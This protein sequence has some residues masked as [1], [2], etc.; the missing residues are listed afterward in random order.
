MSNVVRS[1][2]YR[3]KGLGLLLTAFVLVLTASFGLA[4]CA[5]VVSGNGT[6][7]SGG[8]GGGGTPDTTPP[9]VSISSP[10]AGA[11]LSGTTSVD[12]TASDNVGVTSV[13]LKIDSASFGAPLTAAPYVVAVNTN[14]LSNGN[15]ILTAT[16]SDAAGNVGTSASVTVKVNNTTSNPTPTVA[17]LSP[18]NG[19]S[20]S[21]T[22]M[23]SASATDSVGISHVQF[24]LDGANAGS[25]VTA[26]PYTYAW[27]S[28]KSANGAHILRAVATDMSGNSASSSNVSVTVNNSTPDTTPPAVSITSPVN[29]ATVANTITLSANATDNV[30]VAHVQFRVDGVNSGALD[31]AAPYTD[32]LNTKTLANGAHTITAVATDTSN[33]SAT[34]AAITIHVNNTTTDTTP[35]TVAITAPL[36]G[37]TVS[38]TIALSANATDNVAVA[39]VQF[40]VDG[41]NSGAPDTSAPYAISLN[42]T[43]LSNGNHTLTAVATDTS[44]NSS[45]SAAITVHVNN[46]SADTTPPS[47]PAGLRASAVS[48]SQISLTWTAS[49]DNV[50]VTGYRIYRGGSQVGTSTGVTFQD[51]GL[52]ASTTYS[53][54]VAAFDAAGNVS[55]QSASASATTQSGSSSSGVPSA[56]G[57]FQIPNSAYQSVCPNPTQFNGINGSEGCAGVINDWNGGFADTTRNRLVWWGG[58][59]AGYYGNEVYY[60]DLQTLQIGRY[61]DPVQGGAGS[62]Q[63][64]ASNPLNDLN[65]NGTPAAFHDYQGQVY[66]PTID[67]MFF[68]MG[69]MSRGT[70]T[71]TGTALNDNLGR[72]WP[73]WLFKFG[74]LPNTL[75]ASNTTAWHPQD[76]E[77]GGTLTFSGGKGWA[78]DATPLGEYASTTYDPVSQQVYVYDQYAMYTWDPKTNVGTLRAKSGVLNTSSTSAVVSAIDPVHR[79]LMIYGNNA[80]V[81]YDMTANSATDVSGQLSGCGPTLGTIAPGIDFDTAENV[82]VTWSG[83][84]T[85]YLLNA[86]TSAVSTQ[87][88]SVPAMSCLPVT[89]ANGPGAQ[90]VNGTYGRFRY[91]P[92]IGVFAVVNASDRNAYALRLTPGSGGTGGGTSA[93]VISAVAANSIATSSAAVVWTTNIAATSQVEYGT[94]TSYGA[95]TAVN[96]A[97]VTAHNVGLS[98]LAASTL[99]HYRVHSKDSGGVESISGDAAFATNGS[100]DTT[101]PTVSITAPVSG[102]TVS[103]ATQ[104]SANAADNVGV[105]GVQFML[106]SVNLGAEL[107]SAPY[108][109]SWDTTV[110]TNGS[111]T[112]TARA[113]DAAGNSA[114]STAVTVNVNNAASSGSN[115]FAQRCAAAG[116]IKCVGFDTT[117][118]ILPFISADGNG[119]MQASLDTTVSASGGGSLKFVIPA[120]SGQN[121][122]GSW[123]DSLGAAFPPGTTFFVQY[124]QRFSPE[125]I[126]TNYN[127]NGWKQSIFHM[128]G[129]T[130]ASI[131]LTTQNTWQHG[132][133]E[134]YT[135]CGARGFWTNLPGGDQLLEQG[136]T[137]S[138]GY[139]CHYSNQVP[140]SCAF[141]QPN[142]WMT[143]YYEVHVGNWGQANSTIKAW[144]AYEGGPMK[145]F[146][147]MQGY[148][149]NY[150]NSPSDV[151]DHVTLLPYNT[152]KV[153]SQTNPV[154]Y[155]WYDELIVSRNPI[156]APTGPTPAP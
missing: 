94:S 63:C 11:S 125:F 35:P 102:T 154:A 24:Q 1:T 132:F 145:E 124:R 134:M 92:S 47:V 93:P 54:T 3:S 8:S 76:P 98:G 135:D 99:Y 121:S 89:Y 6:K 29:G 107:T 34:S 108:T 78:R 90:G 36:N 96:S 55:A 20:V 141:Y 19:A 86:T 120:N 128:G 131:E 83:G 72:A 156:P 23:L 75:P 38:G 106:D 137:S 56:L 43:L 62:N 115:S 61:T 7:T 21:K 18:A 111:H 15:H 84:N 119:V 113:R 71:C 100:G 25:P 148:T 150:N 80:A 68:T 129:S 116:V 140:A 70:N 65:W 110:I 149:L 30:A 130:C 133:P 122:S 53:Y 138:T 155:T 101:P 60:L 17:L 153:Q 40:R 117:A 73:T 14:S 31:T 50:G 91:F 37:A 2:K 26:A 151:Y 22:V 147:N 139:N 46:G 143:F 49:T 95:T 64:G 67:A 144:V 66:V 123:S 104:V 52:N 105:V 10:A 103:G 13:Q 5:G 74:E 4:G 87:Y 126:N 28:T 118:E 152:H 12:I 88:G 16:A 112:L 59:H 69:D 42:T 109:T 48:S 82:F 77:F 136:D 32:S 85:V 51:G 57:W 9:T 41:V 97:M 81:K 146:V 33:N 39:S 58:G 142:Q 127:G 45:T 44:N 79:I 114:V 27:D